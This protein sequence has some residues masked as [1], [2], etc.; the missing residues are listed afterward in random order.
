[1]PLLR[2]WL[3][4]SLSP[5]WNNIS[6]TLLTLAYVKAAMEGATWI[7]LRL[8]SKSEAQQVVHI[9]LSSL[10][11]FWP[12]YDKTDWSW[13]LNVLIPAVLGTRLVFKVRTQI[14]VVRRKDCFFRKF[15]KSI[16]ARRRRHWYEIPMTKMYL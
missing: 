9:A 13:R 2:E 8:N 11:L 14:S 15:S 10:L 12:L 1:M 7:R 16:V 6:C 3:L 4:I 5:L